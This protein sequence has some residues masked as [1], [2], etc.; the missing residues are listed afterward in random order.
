MDEEKVDMIVMNG[1]FIGFVAPSGN[2]SYYLNYVT[3]NITSGIKISLLGG[4]IGLVTF[5]GYNFHYCLALSKSVFNASSIVFPTSIS[6]AI[7]A[8]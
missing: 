5:V 8:L 3:P 2:H 1:G 6:P 4:A 7:A